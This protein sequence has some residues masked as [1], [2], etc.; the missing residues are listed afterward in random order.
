MARFHIFA[1]AVA[2]FIETAFFSFFEKWAFWEGA[3]KVAHDGQGLVGGN[4]R[5]NPRLGRWLLQVVLIIW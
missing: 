3:S 1:L 5:V 2:K 4:P